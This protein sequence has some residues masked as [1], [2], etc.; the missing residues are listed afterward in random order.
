MKTK[1]IEVEIGYDGN[2][3]KSGTF[4]ILP[5]G[6]DEGD[7]WENIIKATLVVEVPEKKITMSESQFRQMYKNLCKEAYQQKN[8][9]DMWEPDTY[10]EYALKFEDK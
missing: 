2:E 3:I 8:A 7:G 9:G 4:E 5:Y 1:T 10:M 6:V